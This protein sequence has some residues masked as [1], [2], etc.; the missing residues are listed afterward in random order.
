[1]CLTSNLLQFPLKPVYNDVPSITTA[2][3]RP[4]HKKLDLEVPFENSATDG[5]PRT[6]TQKLSSTHI[7]QNAMLAIGVIQNNAF[8]ITPVK[9]V[10]QLRPCFDG[11]SAHSETVEMQQS[12]EDEDA[13]VQETKMQ[14]VQLKRTETERMEATRLQS[15]AHYKSKEESE[16]RVKLNVYQIGKH[17]IYSIF[18]TVYVN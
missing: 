5:V 9:N 1:M 2:Y 11:H 7:P 3:Y 16:P 13:E 8:H 18:V 10:L 4:R 12:S 17:I 15:Y 6:A 14:Q